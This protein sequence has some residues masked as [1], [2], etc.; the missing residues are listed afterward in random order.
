MKKILGS[1]LVM[2]LSLLVMVGCA[3]QAEPAPPG[4]H[5]ETVDLGKQRKGQALVP[6][7][8][9]AQESRAGTMMVR[10]QSS[11]PG[12]GDYWIYAT[13]GKLPMRVLVHDEELKSGAW[14]IHISPDQIC[15]SCKEVYVTVGK[16]LE[17]RYYCYSN[18][19]QAPSQPAPIN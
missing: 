16:H 14:L 11:Q 15:P 2:G 19:H 3:A 4:Y 6:D 17:R 10:S 13:V 9:P 12:P 7:L 1:S 5:Y 18:V 8:N